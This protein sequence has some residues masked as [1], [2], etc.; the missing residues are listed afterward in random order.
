[1]ISMSI[2][3][4][5][6]VGALGSGLA[7]L[8]VHRRLTAA[9]MSDNTRD[10]V[11]LVAGLIATLSA[12]VLGL[13]ISNSNSFFNTQQMNLQMLAAHLTQLDGMLR[14]YGPEADPV[15][16]NLRATV[17]RNYKR[18]WDS[19]PNTATASLTPA[20]VEMTNG[21]MD[22]LLD[23]LKP[24]TEDQKRLLAKASDLSGAIAG[25]RVFM[26]MQVAAPAP[27]PLLLIMICWTFVL[28]FSFGVISH[29]NPTVIVTVA[30]GALA[31]GSALFLILELEHPYTGLIR[32]SPMPLL[33]AIDFMSK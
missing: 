10:Q 12:L 31:I 23:T 14:E 19:D 15:R 1:M 28:F 18:I 8:L 27:M 33:Q 11:K 6:T 3:V 22:K 9:H 32:I 7:G 29:T 24:E 26:S 13:L 21:R 30:S 5:A 16:D 4:F 25:E 2:V 20:Y 17:M